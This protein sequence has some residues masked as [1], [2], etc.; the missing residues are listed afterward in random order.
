[1]YSNTQTRHSDAECAATE[2]PFP[3]AWVFDTSL[4]TLLQ[5]NNGADYYPNSDYR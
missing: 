4:F 5:I 3:K 2:L 1:M